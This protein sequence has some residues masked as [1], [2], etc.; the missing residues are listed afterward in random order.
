MLIYL[1]VIN[2]L[3]H[4]FIP[5]TSIT[6]KYVCYMI[7]FFATVLVLLGLETF[8][9][10]LNQTTSKCFNHFESSIDVHWMI[11][12][13]FL[14]GVSM[15]LYILSAIEFI[16]AQSPFNMKGLV[17]R[18]CC[19]LFGVGTLIHVSISKAFTSN[20]ILWR[21]TCSTDM[22]KES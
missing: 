13:N 1:V 9:M 17:L 11:L 15:F 19:A 14:I 4:S 3:F 18:I 8:E 10:G 22:W 5:R 20:N 21:S 7:I 6:I 2:P 12:P 16:C